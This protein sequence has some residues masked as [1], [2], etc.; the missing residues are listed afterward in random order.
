MFKESGGFS[1]MFSWLN[2]VMM[3]INVQ[4]QVNQTDFRLFTV[5]TMTDTQEVRLIISTIHSSVS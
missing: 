4:A 2:K 3:M 1:E 5:K